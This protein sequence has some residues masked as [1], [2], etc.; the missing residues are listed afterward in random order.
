LCGLT[1][2]HI[3]VL[4]DD[5]WEGGRGFPMKDVGDLTLDQVF[6]LLCD[7]KLLMNRQK[8][9]SA[10]EVAGIGIKNDGMIKGRDAEGNPIVG[11]IVGKSK[12]RM[13]ME[14]AAERNKKELSQK[15]KRRRGI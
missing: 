9:F 13:L 10:D 12:A 11:K 7:R 1:P 8:G 15:P 5:P 4:V 2:W 6:M 3:R 14:A